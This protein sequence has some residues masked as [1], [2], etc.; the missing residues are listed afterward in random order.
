M[1]A[2]ALAVLVA[3]AAHAGAQAGA[4]RSLAEVSTAQLAPGETVIGAVQLDFDGDGEY[5]LA[6]L[7]RREGD[8]RFARLFR[9]T[10]RNLR[11]G[12]SVQLPPD[13]TAWAVGDV[14][15]D[16]GEEVVLFT[17]RGVY[18]WRPGAEDAERFARLA[19]PEFL[20]QLPQ[21]DEVILWEAGVR[22]LDRDGLVDLVL[23][24]AN[25][26]RLAF[27]RR[28]EQGARF[29]EALISVPRDPTAPGAW[30]SVSS[31]GRG[32][33]GSR[34]E[35]ELRL[36]IGVEA[37][38]DAEGAL[39]STLLSVRESVPAPQLF[40]W[41]AD[42][43]LDL[44]AQTPRQLHVW[45]QEP[46]GSFAAAPIASLDLPV[47]ADRD[48]RLDASYSSHVLD[49]SGDGRADCVIVAGDRRADSVRTQGLFFV[50]DAKAK[51]GA[52]FGA[53]G[54][55]QDL[56][57]FAGFVADVDFADVNSD[58]RPDLIIASVRPDLLDQLR[59]VSSETLDSDLH[60]Y[61]NQGGRF[62]RRPEL[63]YRL[64]FKLRRFDLTARFL[65]DLT[66]D[67]ISELLVRD[68]PESLR[69]LMVRPERGGEK[70]NVI[71]RPIWQ[72][73]VHEDALIRIERQRK[74]GRQPD[75]LVQERAQVLRVRFP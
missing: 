23:P 44:L 54:R 73:D 60:V 25:G 56:L 52:L 62:S 26:Y 12:A 74:F 55:P 72:L 61:L 19:R 5:D 27:Q 50:H 2:L 34:S 21:S 39:P 18:A 6:I 41:D 57:V 37:G 13:V 35:G 68:Q 67:G 8:L 69:V 65:G 17:A 75:V 24:E 49:F 71:E 1:R 43:D 29:E 10:E 40:D 46:A 58:G 47:A 11:A 36:T 3:T 16:A 51:A 59:S 9:S 66:G 32:W 22:D 4:P 14:H 28:D 63:A 33:R 30:I 53:D 70:L 38:V 20:W 15:A 45:R 64:T 48:R 31:E 7:G 42:G